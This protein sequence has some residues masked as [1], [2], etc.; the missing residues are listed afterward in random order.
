MSTHHFS[1]LYT[2]LPHHLIKDKL[3]D[4]TERRF[5]REKALFPSDVYKKYKLW[6]CQNVCEALV[7]LLDNTFIRFGTKVC[8][9]IVFLVPLFVCF[10]RVSFCPLSLPLG[11]GGWLRFVITLDFSINIFFLHFFSYLAF[12][13]AFFSRIVEN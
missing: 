10:A 4:L 13:F 2:M 11:V 1:T 9:Q 8:R 3:I 6:S 12:L 5:S 7:Y